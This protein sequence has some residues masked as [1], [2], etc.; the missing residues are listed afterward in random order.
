[1]SLLSFTLNPRYRIK[2]KTP[3][4]TT[5][6]TTPCPSADHAWDRAWS[7]AGDQPASIS[8]QVLP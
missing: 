6:I 4:S 7:I 2:V 5:I 3:Q 8:V 1:M